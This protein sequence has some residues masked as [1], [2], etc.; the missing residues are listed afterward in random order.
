MFVNFTV[1]LEGHFKNPKNIICLIRD[2]F[3]N[4]IIKIYSKIKMTD[5]VMEILTNNIKQF[6]AIL[7]GVVFYYYKIYTFL[8]E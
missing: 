7:K 3:V 5:E 2:C 1:V 6:L 8:E 4:S